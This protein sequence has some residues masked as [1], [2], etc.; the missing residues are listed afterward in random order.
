MKENYEALIK[1]LEDGYYDEL[2]GKIIGKDYSISEG[3]FAKELFALFRNDTSDTG[4]IEVDSS[5]VVSAYKRFDDYEGIK[6]SINNT[7]TRIENEYKGIKSN[8]EKMVNTTGSVRDDS[9]TL[10]L[11]YKDNITAPNLKANSAMINQMELYKKAKVTQVQQM[12]NIHALAFAAKL[13]AAKDMFNQ[14]KAVLYKALY[15]I[16]GLKKDD[17][18]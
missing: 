11:G 5:Y 18:K 7:K 14:D 4:S 12:S 15:R 8:L 9:M 2:R 1:K 6:K 3:D 10:S 13:D 16:Q 17:N